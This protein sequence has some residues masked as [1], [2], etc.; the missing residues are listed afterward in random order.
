MTSVDRLLT[1][2]AVT[3]SETASETVPALDGGLPAGD[4]LTLLPRGPI[5][6][7]PRRPVYIGGLCINHN[8][9][10]RVW[11]R[12]FFFG[13]KETNRLLSTDQTEQPQKHGNI[14][15]ETDQMRKT[16]N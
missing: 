4:G 12:F 15:K 9:C 16:K 2:G 5:S 1:A 10:V 14:K 11:F 7:P 6:S 13:Q 3:G 8:V